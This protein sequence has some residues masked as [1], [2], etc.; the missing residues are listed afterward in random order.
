[1]RNTAI[2][3][4]FAKA[5]YRTAHERLEQLADAAVA[6]ATNN[7]DARR[8]LMQ[9]ASSDPELLLNLFEPWHRPGCDQYLIPAAKRR[10]EARRRSSETNGRTDTT[11]ATSLTSGTKA[12]SHTTSGASQVTA[13]GRKAAEPSHIDREA[14]R[15]AVAAVISKLDTFKIDGTPVARP[16]KR[17]TTPSKTRE[18]HPCRKRQTAP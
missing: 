6:E 12:A 10:A 16:T 2:T 8:H 4:A 18:D 14:A 1:M 13:S 5:G 11:A 7:D 15:G 17:F 9:A 3:T